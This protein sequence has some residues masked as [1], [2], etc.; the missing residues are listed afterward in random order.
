MRRSRRR[1]AAA[2]GIAAA[3]LSAAPA[4]ALDLSKPLALPA[5]VADG[6]LEAGQ[7]R[8][9]LPAGD[10]VL[11]A[12]AREETIGRRGGTERRGEGVAAWAALVQDGELRALVA[13]ALP[14]EDFPN[15][16]RQGAP[17]CTDEDSIERLDLSRTLTRPECL[18]VYGHRDL[19]AWLGARTPRTLAW[20]R[21][22]GVADSVP[23]V[24]FAYRI[25]TDG[26]YGGVSVILPT[27]PFAADEEATRWA[28]G[29]RDAMEPLLTGRAGEARLP[30]A[31]TAA[32]APAASASTAAPVASSNR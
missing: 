29:L 20:L 14:L 21:G 13:L 27:A 32:P 18:G 6:V 25:R 9:R 4:A 7:R 30:A 23:V 10:W 11:T 12:L 31:P 19:G 22:Q 1:A 5:P 2:A 8:L 16:H 15:V 3:L 28:R 17:G 24:R 26:T